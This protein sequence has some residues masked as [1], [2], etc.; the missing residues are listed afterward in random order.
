MGTLHSQFALR[1]EIRGMKLHN[2]GTSPLLLQAIPKYIHP[3][4]TC[5]FMHTN[6]YHTKC[7]NQSHMDLTPD[8]HNFFC[9][10]FIFFFFKHQDLMENIVLLTSTSDTRA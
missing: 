7:T 4:Y 6:S 10:T 3:T 1:I 9:Q 8:R 2:E 5:K